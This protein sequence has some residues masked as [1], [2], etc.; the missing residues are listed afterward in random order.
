MS[1][2]HTCITMKQ[3]Y[4]VPEHLPCQATSFL[5]SSSIN[6]RTLFPKPAVGNWVLQPSLL[7]L[8]PDCNLSTTWASKWNYKALKMMC[9]KVYF[10]M[11]SEVCH[12]YFLTNMNLSITK[13]HS[14]WIYN[15]SSRQRFSHSAAQNPFS[16]P[17][18]Y[19]NA[20][21]NNIFP[22]SLFLQ[23]LWRDTHHSKYF[24]N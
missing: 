22:K 7:D 5:F 16:S 8:F 18:G 21:R 1:C 24:K 23:V 3:T 14:M 13:Y 9:L 4:T 12:L 17:L 10:H 19:K 20:A 15:T 6:S 2:V 11:L